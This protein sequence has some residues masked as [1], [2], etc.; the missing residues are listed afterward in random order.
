MAMFPSAA[1]LQRQR[2]SSL[3]EVRRRQR[4]ADTAIERIERRLFT[5]L[6]RKTLITR[7]VALSLVPLWN[8]YIAKTRDL[9]KGLA[10]FISVTSI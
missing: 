9:E 6:D 4:A 10:D 1:E 5:L 2:K 3:R 8:D 7:E